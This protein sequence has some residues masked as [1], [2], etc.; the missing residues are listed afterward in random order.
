MTSET[1][2]IFGTAPD[3]I[4]D[5]PGLRFA[6]FVQG[7]THGCPGCHNKASQP[8]CGGTVERLD[9]LVARIAANGLTQ[10]VTISGGEPFEQALACAKLARRL[11]ERGL[12]IWTYSGYRYEDLAAR[13]APSPSL[14]GE[15]KSAALSSVDPDGARDL[16]AATDVLVDG[17]FVQALHSYDLSWRGSSNQRLIDVAA[18][19]ACGR[20]VLWETREDFPNK[21]ASW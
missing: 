5:G 3:S 8:A 7:C 4:V 2:R 17:P 15:G 21:P 1:I 9:D 6:V 13:G 10:G 19:R 11:K 12:G 14:D 18:T 20:I 16:L